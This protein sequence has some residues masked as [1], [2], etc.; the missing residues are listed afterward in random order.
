M[1]AFKGEYSHTIDDKGRLI[2]PSRLREQLGEGF[3]VTKGLDGC[4][5]VFDREGWENFEDKLR[6][7]PMDNRDARMLSRFFLAGASDAEL[8]KQGRVLL[9]AN[10]ISHAELAKDVVVIGAGNRVEIWSRER[11][12][13]T[14]FDNIDDIADKM[15]AYGL[16][17]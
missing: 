6:A 14:S 9:P 8:D 10:L 3:V 17:I 7:L 12:N 2:I 11:W 16:S 4:L 13:D 5:F 15:A 1:T